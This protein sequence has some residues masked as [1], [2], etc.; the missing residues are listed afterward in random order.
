MPSA[1]FVIH[2]YMVDKRLV[3]SLKCYWKL[4]EEELGRPNNFVRLEGET[5]SEPE[6]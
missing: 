6:N 1:I 4:K 5:D 3:C 2:Y